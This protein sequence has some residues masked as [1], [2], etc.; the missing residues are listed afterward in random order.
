VAEPGA[1]VEPVVEL[2]AEPRSAVGPVV[3]L[4]VELGPAV[5]LAAELGPAVGLAAEPGPVV[6]LVVELGPVVEPVT[7]SG[8]T[9]A[10]M[11]ARSDWKYPAMAAPEPL[12][13][14]ARYRSIRVNDSAGLEWAKGPNRVGTDRDHPHPA[15]DPVAAK[16]GMDDASP[17]LT[18]DANSWAGARV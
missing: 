2:A 17:D 3:E 9:V 14:C 16:W 15:I 11:A 5:G 7:E 8:P 12:L 18:H 13:D 4:V 10:I 6:E 1:T